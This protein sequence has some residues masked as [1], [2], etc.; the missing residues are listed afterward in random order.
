MNEKGQATLRIR[1]QKL[2]YESIKSI[3]WYWWE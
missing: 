1:K 3:R 2:N